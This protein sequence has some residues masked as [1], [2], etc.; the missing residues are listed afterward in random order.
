MR[1]ALDFLSSAARLPLLA[2]SGFPL[3]FLDLLHRPSL[4][5]GLFI[6]ILPILP[7]R[8][9]GFD[10][11]LSNTPVLALSGGGNREGKT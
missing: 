5:P 6:R 3:C 2:L 11:I 10:L 7:G 8:S 9:L 4:F 1:Y